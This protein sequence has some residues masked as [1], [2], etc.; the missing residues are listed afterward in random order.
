MPSNKTTSYKLSSNTTNQYDCN[1][2]PVYINYTGRVNDITTNWNKELTTSTTTTTT[3]ND[4]EFKTSVNYF[5]GRKLIGLKHELSNNDNDNDNKLQLKL[6]EKQDD[7][8]N[9]TSDN[10]QYKE[11]GT[12][13]NII[14]YDHERI[15]LLNDP[16]NKMI[17][18]ISLS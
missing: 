5:R 10:I 11:I 3:T 18:W 15:P 12:C 14:N 2:L 7:L 16:V 8:M 1:V 6:F 9:G 17:E 4:N 13:K